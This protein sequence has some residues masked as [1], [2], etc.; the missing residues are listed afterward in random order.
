[1]KLTNCFS[2]PYCLCSTRPCLAPL[3]QGSG[4]AA[5]CWVWLFAFLNGPNRLSRCFATSLENTT[6][7]YWAKF[8]L[9]QLA[10]VE[11]TI[12]QLC[13]QSR[14]RKL[15]LLLCIASE[16]ILPLIGEALWIN[17]KTICSAGRRTT[18]IILLIK[19]RWLGKVVTILWI[20]ILTPK[21]VESSL[22]L[23]ERWYGKIFHSQ[24]LFWLL[25]IN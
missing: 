9:S 6:E 1:M 2:G 11:R 14:R 5:I 3:A 18:G 19:F 23:P 12:L 4:V 8:T 16:K 15:C 7:G 25:K 20:V 22:L 17:E 24:A 10:A 21:L 13:E